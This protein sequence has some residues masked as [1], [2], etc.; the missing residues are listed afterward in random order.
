MTRPHCPS[1][2]RLPHQISLG[3]GKKGIRRLTDPDLRLKDQDRDGIQAEVLYGILGATS[4]LDDD[5]AAGEMLR[6]YNDWLAGF[7][8]KHPER[9]AGLACIP[10]HDIGA[11]V[12][13]IERV[14]RRGN[15][16]GLEIGREAVYGEAADTLLAEAA[17]ELVKE[18]MQ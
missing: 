2:H 15:V 16:R 9:Y 10:N 18:A 3:F 7:C 4:R 13:E 12:S 1:L 17:D 11:P 14:A 6:I 5:E 8:S